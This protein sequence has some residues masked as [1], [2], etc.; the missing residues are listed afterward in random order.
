VSALFPE[1]P[2]RPEPPVT[3]DTKQWWDHTR[4]ARLA[5]QSCRRCGSVQLYPRHLCVACGAT[6]LEF[7][8]ASGRGTIYSRTVAAK[9]PRPECFV[10]PYVVALVRLDEGPLVLTNIVGEGALDADCDDRVTVTWDPLPDGRNLPLFR[11]GLQ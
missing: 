3:A 4:E 1:F 5:I 6:E 11:V 7:V 9:S 10:P 8:V 2:S